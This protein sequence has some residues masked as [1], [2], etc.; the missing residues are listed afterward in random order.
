MDKTVLIEKRKNLLNQSKGAGE[1]YLNSGF[2]DLTNFIEPQKLIN[3]MLSPSQEPLVIQK[4]VIVDKIKKTLSPCSDLEQLKAAMVSLNVDKPETNK[5]FTKTEWN[6]FKEKQIKK[7]TDKYFADLD[8]LLQMT[9]R[10]KLEH[11][12][13]S[14][15]KMYLSYG[16]LV[17]VSQYPNRD[18]LILRSPLINL[19]I[20]VVNSDN[21]NIL[22]RKF[23]EEGTIQANEILGN[24]L[25]DQYEI[26]TNLPGVLSTLES[27]QNPT[28]TF[29]K[30]LANVVPNVTIEDEFIP[31][32]KI[33]K[34]KVESKYK[35]RLVI[36]KNFAV[37]LINPVGGKLLKDYDEILQQDYEFPAVNSIFNSNLN[38]LIY[39]RDE[40]FEI[41]NPLNLAQ[42][43]AVVNSLNKNLLIYGPPGTGKS[44]VVANII[45]NAITKQ[46]S[47]L[48]VS[49]KKA[50]LDVLDER[51]MAVNTLAMTAFDNKNK[52]AFYKKIL[53][54]NNAILRSHAHNLPAQNAGYIK[55]LDYL[56]QL[57]TLLVHKDMFSSNLYQFLA[58]KDRVNLHDY[59][60][61]ILP[62]SVFITLHNCMPGSLDE[63]AKNIFL[64]NDVMSEFAELLGPSFIVSRKIFNNDL[65]TSFLSI[66][67]EARPKDRA[68]L[69]LT[70]ISKAE[71]LVKKPLF[72]IKF[73]EEKKLDIERTISLLKR[74]KEYNITF[75]EQYKPIYNFLK[76]HDNYRDYLQYYDWYNKTKL[77]SFIN[78][79]NIKDDINS[80][81]HNYWSSKA[82]NAKKLDNI[83]IDWY[84][85]NLRQKLMTDKAL[86][87]KWSELVRKA[88]LVHKPSVN[89]IIRDSYETLRK[90]FP[91]WILS[92]DTAA[93][94]LPLKQNEFDL[95]IFDESSQMRIERGTPLVY[96]CKNSIVSGDDKQ[97]K[98]TSFFTSINELG[99]MYE[100][101]LDNVDSLLDKAKSSN[102]MSFT[103]LNHY[104]SVTEELIHFSNHYF[105]NDQLLCIT[106][107]NHFAKSIDVINALGVYNRDRGIN[108]DEANKVIQTLSANVNN[109]K[110]MI[111]ITFNTKQADH[112][113]LLANTNPTLRSMI[114]NLTLKIRSLES[115]QGD[116]ADLV[117]VSTTF[118]KDKHGKFVQNFGPVN[119]DGGMNRINVMMTRAKN[120]LVVI[121][122]FMANEITNEEN[123]NLFIFKSFIQ[124]AEQLQDNPNM[125]GVLQNTS[126]SLESNC[127]EVVNGIR[128][129]FANDPR[130]EIEQNKKIGSHN[131]DVAIKLK[132]SDEIKL[133]VILDDDI[134]IDTYLKD[135]VTFIE[136]IDRQKYYED[137][138]YR[139]VR[140]NK[141]EWL[142]NS[143]NII[144][145]IKNLVN[146]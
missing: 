60:Q 20:E 131:I 76:T 38:S 74:I 30:H 134:K 2:I 52:D 53:I 104:R 49:E 112:I 85:S 77:T 27:Q 130:I 101:H 35:N 111:V 21:G 136:D 91:I 72:S 46:K 142:I 123:R 102:W 124:Y 118:G 56:N 4:G 94:I 106:K 23:N 138:Q 61:N 103:L 50:A 71:V 82:F 99:E 41:N 63:K 137:R 40:L 141:I 96:R 10:A 107:N 37:S 3:F 16:T 70:F 146:Y 120:K 81:I 86:D 93:S 31:Y 132:E 116:E 125:L 51:L 83:I 110:S 26:K 75:V 117:V 15:W 122:S 113:R 25:D 54:L 73:A 44:E 143:K 12:D 64:L 57:Q 47:V 127:A 144:N 9:I 90:I 7:A 129:A 145:N 95:G 29:F 59:N 97:L 109:Y 88:N 114:E 80:I 19:E 66:L 39:D 45:V 135:K 55:I 8:E 1:L 22:I 133:L 100:G 24:T 13:K 62:I 18:D 11:F 139:T 105:Y 84:A 5:T 140:I 17:G 69:L 79:I 42:K 32:I 65:L 92:P 128:E 36:Q 48:V 121:K 43:L 78:K 87:Q 33:P 34:D 14:I 6:D 115:V 28:D 89:R 119:Q 126:F 58:I 68:Y 67:L 98:P 108:E